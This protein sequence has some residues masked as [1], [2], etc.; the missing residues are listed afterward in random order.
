M[1]EIVI[2]PKKIQK[3]PYCGSSNIMIDY[4]NGTIVC[5]DCGS[6]IED[7]VYEEYTANIHTLGMRR[8]QLRIGGQKYITIPD[9]EKINY[10]FN[11]LKLSIKITRKLGPIDP[12][13]L[14]EI[15]QLLQ[16]D[17]EILNNECLV[18]II[19]K[20]GDRYKIIAI[21]ITKSIK[22]G[23]YPFLSYFSLKYNI[24]KNRVKKLIKS[25][26]KCIE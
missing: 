17:N 23:D 4:K 1:A 5:R 19:R 2:V 9:A 25:I 16:Y 7:T 11:K 26:S 24:P 21:E 18:K 14:G 20:L 13:I 8:Y 22:Q 12:R 15:Y 3:C 10:Q 6:V